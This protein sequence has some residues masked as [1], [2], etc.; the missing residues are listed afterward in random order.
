VSSVFDDT[1]VF[2]PLLGSDTTDGMP[3]PHGLDLAVFGRI[4]LSLESLADK[5]ARDNDRREALA[6]LIPVDYSLSAQGIFPAAGELFLDLGAPPLGT[7]WQV[8]WVV[9]GGETA[10]ATPAGAVYVYA[11]GTPPLDLNLANLKDYATKLP[12]PVSYGTHQFVINQGEHLW[13]VFSGGTPTDSYVV[14]AKVEQWDVSARSA[15]AVY[16]E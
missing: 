5:A 3:A 14:T 6:K 11:Q 9:A 10:T 8:R 13:A 15:A 1:A 4:A 12:A 2:P 7:F 16:A